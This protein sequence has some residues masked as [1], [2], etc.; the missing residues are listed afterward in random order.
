MAGETMFAQIIHEA[1]STLK[2]MPAPLPVCCLCGL[3]QDKTGHSLD[4]ERWV[5]QRTYRNTHEAMSADG[6]LTHTYCPNCFT[7][8]MDRMGSS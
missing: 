5:T 2:R 6:V 4:H 7:Q 3:V 1:P 8:V